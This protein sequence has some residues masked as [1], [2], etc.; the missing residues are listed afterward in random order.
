MRPDSAAVQLAAAIQESS[1]AESW[2]SDAAD[3]L[4]DWTEARKKKLSRERG[5]SSL[6]TLCGRIRQA[7][8]RAETIN[9]RSLKEME[10]ALQSS[11]FLCEDDNG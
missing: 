3:W 2:T 9:V 11:T 6:S 5:G 4:A 7:H 8:D 1:R 10:K